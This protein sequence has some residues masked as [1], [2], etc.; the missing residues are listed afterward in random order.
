[1]QAVDDAEGHLVVRRDDRRVVRGPGELAGE[2]VAEVGAPVPDDDRPLAHPPR[3]RPGVERPLAAA[4]VEPVQGAGQVQHVPVAEHGEVVDGERDAELLVDGDRE[5]RRVALGLDD[6]HR[7]PDVDL[8]DRGHRGRPRRDDAQRLDT[9]VGQVRDG[10]GRRQVGLV[11]DRHRRH[12]VADLTGRELDRV[13]RA[14]RAVLGH[15]VHED[16][17]AARALGGQGPRDAVRPVV[18]L[19]D[20]RQDAVARVRQDL[21]GAVEDAGDRHRRD[22]GTGGDVPDVRPVLRC[23]DHRRLLP[24]VPPRLPCRPGWWGA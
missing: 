2:V 15:A 21:R 7:H 10:L 17:D 3:R 8:A 16:A 20:H 18:E 4:R 22:A 12:R 23:R 13:E 6:E 24:T 19:A 1:M 5:E 11:P 9:L 14:R